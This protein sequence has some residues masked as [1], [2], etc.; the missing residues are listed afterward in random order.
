MKKKY[1]EYKENEGFFSFKSLHYFLVKFGPNTCW[2]VFVIYLLFRSYVIEPKNSGLRVLY[3]V[4]LMVT[5][6]K[7]YHIFQP[8]RNVEKVAYYFISF[9]TSVLLMVS[10]WL[11]SKYKKT[12]IQKLTHSISRLAA[13]SFMHTKQEKKQEMLDMFR[14]LSESD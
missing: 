12:K 4:L 8:F 6:F 2:F 14:E 13:F 10:V 1:F 3:C 7:Y 11:I 5:V 9:A